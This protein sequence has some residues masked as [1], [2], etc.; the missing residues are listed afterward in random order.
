MEEKAKLK[1]PCPYCG[2]DGDFTR[3]E[4]PHFIIYRCPQC[5]AEL[6]INSLGAN[7][8]RE[9]KKEEIFAIRVSRG[10][11][12]KLKKLPPEVIREYLRQLVK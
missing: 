5:G 9:G 7:Y 11:K 10:L 2:W 4:Y 8:W 1:E 3:T 12:E 6:V